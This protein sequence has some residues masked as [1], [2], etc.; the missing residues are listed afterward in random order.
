MCIRDSFTVVVRD[1]LDE[2]HLDVTTIRGFT[3]SHDMQVQFEESNVLVFTFENIL[4][5]DSMTNEPASNGWLVF[6]IDRKPNQSFGTEITN[7]AAIYFDFNEPII[8]NELVNVLTE[9]VS[10]FSPS[11]N[12]IPAKVT[13]TLTD[14]NTLLE[15]TLENSS[16]TTICLL[17]TS[18]S[19]RDATLSRM[20]SSA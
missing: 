12:K 5:V 17:Y 19:P 3:A 2:E 4:L 11:E 15:F 14:E 20:P 18:P 13:P 6:D 10:V 7:Q 1:T 8:T 9:P 16:V